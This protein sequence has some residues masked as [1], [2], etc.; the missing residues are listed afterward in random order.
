MQTRQ[1]S[2]EISEETYSR[3]QKA[4]EEAKTRPEALASDL[5]A[6]A[7][8]TATP[9]QPKVQFPGVALI[10]NG[11]SLATNL[12]GSSENVTKPER[13]AAPSTSHRLPELSKPMHTGALTPEA[14]Q[15]RMLLETRIRELSL[16]ID[17][18]EPDKKEDYLLQY[19]MLAA[20]LDSII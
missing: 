16:L 20:E 9:E 3:L 4:A 11:F 2:I 19:A 8:Q 7:L 10:K 12:A 17:T 1:I 5:I 15:R 14:M 18:A 6:I 13:S